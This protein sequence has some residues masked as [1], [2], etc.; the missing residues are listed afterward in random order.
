MSWGSRLREEGRRGGRAGDAEQWYTR[1]G[2]RGGSSARGVSVEV[3]QRGEAATFG[4][5]GAVPLLAADAPLLLLEHLLV[6]AQDGEEDR[7]QHEDR[8][9]EVAW[10]S[11]GGDVL[12]HAGRE[13]RRAV[14]TTARPQAAEAALRG[15]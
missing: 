12:I 13:L 4:A 6:L 10:P 15:A 8:E 3:R 5:C 11:K 2:P 7:E 9:E 1:R 14:T